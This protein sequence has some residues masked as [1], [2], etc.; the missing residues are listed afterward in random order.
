MF[1]PVLYLNSQLGNF[2]IEQTASVDKVWNY[3]LAA[4]ESVLNDQ[5]P[6]MIEIIFEYKFPSCDAELL[7]LKGKKRKCERLYRK[8]RSVDFKADF[9][10]NTKI[11]F[12]KLLKKGHSLSTISCTGILNVKTMRYW[13]PYLAKRSIYYQNV[14]IR[15]FLLQILMFYF[16]RLEHYCI[17]S[18]S[19][20]SSDPVVD[21]WTVYFLHSV[22]PER[23]E[24]ATY[25][26]NDQRINAR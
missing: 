23:F 5:I 26:F 18:G 7:F 8:T 16:K 13:K 24:E 12:D 19:W 6:L 9:D 25:C 11:Y 4:E 21:K 3:Y 20:V 15:K 14:K 22:V 1:S 10:L 17:N 2:S